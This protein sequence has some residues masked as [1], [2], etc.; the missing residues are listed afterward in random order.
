MERFIMN[1]TAP[2]LLEKPSEL[3]NAFIEEYSDIHEIDK[4]KTLKHI[5]TGKTIEELKTKWYTHLDENNIDKAYSVYD[6]DYH[7]VDLWLC[8][9]NQSR[10][11]L[12]NLYK[13]TLKNDSSII[14]LTNDVKHIVD[15]G[16]GLGHTTIAL[17]QM[18]PNAKVYGTNL[19]N[20]KQWKFCEKKA[21][22]Y[23][24]ELLE[25]INDINITVDMVFAS[26]YFEHIL[27][28]IKHLKEIINTLSPKYFIIANS[29]NRYSIGHFRTYYITGVLN[30][31]IAE[32]EK[33]MNKIFNRSLIDF[34]YEKMKTNF[35]NGRPNIW[36]K[37]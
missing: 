10:S 19:K 32:N 15:I 9:K 29:F 30:I 18:Y 8:F 22:Q 33:N 12:R 27:K 28:P 26:E 35:F 4:D 1:V 21:K 6:D 16:C 24:F 7:F 20:T 37:I 34:G 23:D 5:K 31:E 13:P 2:I 3:L 11:Y 14:E 36:K 17:R 25:S